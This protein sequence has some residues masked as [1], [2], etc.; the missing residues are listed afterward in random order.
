LE[1]LRL[2]QQIAKKALD[3]LGIVL[4]EKETVIVRDATIQRFE[5]TFEIIWKLVKEY[6]KVKEGLLCNSPKSCFRECFSINLLTEKE[7]ILALQMTDDRNLSSHTY[8]EELADAIFKRIEE[9]NKLLTKI[10]TQI[11]ERSEEQSSE[12]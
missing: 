5:Y 8:H 11:V 6:L 7:S 3:K 10:Y 1:K 2:N 12:E 4:R 9:Y